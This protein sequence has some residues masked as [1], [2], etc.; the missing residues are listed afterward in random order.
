MSR[1]S[2][3]RINK[4]IKKAEYETYSTQGLNIGLC[5][6][7]VIGTATGSVY[8]KPALYMIGFAVIGLIVGVIIG[9]AIKRKNR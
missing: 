4:N 3:R 8:G 1:L 7:L 2:S 5:M 6:G 9:S